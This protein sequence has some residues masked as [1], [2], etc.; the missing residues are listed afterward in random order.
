MLLQPALFYPYYNR[1]CNG[2]EPMAHHV[3]MDRI[4]VYI[5]AI[6]IRREGNATDI[7]HLAK[8]L[9]RPKLIAPEE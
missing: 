2:K 7:Y 5:A 4:M 1:S 3:A 8:K 6:G 9:I